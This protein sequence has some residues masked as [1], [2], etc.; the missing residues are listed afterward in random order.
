MILE[1]NLKLGA[2]E[3]KVTRRVGADCHK[4]GK[5]DT[6]KVE[7]SLSLKDSPEWGRA[8]SW[9]RIALFLSASDPH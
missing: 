5:P 2:W 9:D 1:G 4:K 7:G 8:Q 3:L 6:W